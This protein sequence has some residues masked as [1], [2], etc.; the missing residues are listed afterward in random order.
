MADT[1]K[2]EHEELDEATIRHREIKEVATKLRHLTAA[3][4]AEVINRVATR[5]VTKQVS[6]QV[7]G[8]A[9]FIRE[10]GIVGVGIGLVL[11]IQMKA[12]VDT[13]MASLVNPVT[14]LILPGKERLSA[15][16]AHLTFRGDTVEVGWGA[17]VYSLFTFLM[18]AFI[19]YAAYKLLKLDKLAKKK[20]A[21]ASL[22]KKDKNNK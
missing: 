11:G 22:V 19:I 8:F 17:L 13:V 1:S 20:D 4:K 16:T 18:V 7:S 12:V 5:Q 9:D 15:K 3:E 2:Q 14:Q 6:K 21:A 10:Q